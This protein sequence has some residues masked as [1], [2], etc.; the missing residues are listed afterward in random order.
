MLQY[1]CV[2]NNVNLKTITVESSA[3]S[4]TNITERVWVF[5]C[6]TNIGSQFPVKLHICIV[7]FMQLYSWEHTTLLCYLSGK[8]E[9]ITIRVSCFRLRNNYT[10]F[11]G[12]IL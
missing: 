5:N 10:V 3:E 12:K 11:I 4:I 1:D 7:C 6:K 8:W 2:I 9:R